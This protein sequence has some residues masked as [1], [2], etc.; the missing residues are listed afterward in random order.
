MPE[1]NSYDLIYCSV[2]QKQRYE[3][4]KKEKIKQIQEDKN[5]S[6]KRKEILINQ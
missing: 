6:N 2:S 1:N 3:E 4:T 5:L